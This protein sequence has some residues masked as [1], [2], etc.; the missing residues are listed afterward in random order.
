M[1]PERCEQLLRYTRFILSIVEGD[2]RSHCSEA[3]QTEAR[4]VLGLLPK[5]VAPARRD[6]VVIVDPDVLEPAAERE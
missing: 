4:R 5:E 2:L 3:V 1:T 6:P